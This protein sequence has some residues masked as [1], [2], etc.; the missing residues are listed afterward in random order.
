MCPH[1]IGGDI[2]LYLS[3]LSCSSNQLC[4]CAFS[5]SIEQASNTRRWPNARLLLAYRLRRWANISPVL[6]YRVVFDATLKVGQRHRRRDNINP[7]FAG[8]DPEVGGGGRGRTPTLANIS[9]VLG[10]RVVFD[11]TLKVGQ[12]HRRQANINPAFAG[13]DPEEGAQGAHAHP[14]LRQIL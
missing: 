11:A 10:Y 9:P 14:F 8:A 3:S 12:R 2:L 6:G 5:P 1:Y 13:A 4:V 7:A